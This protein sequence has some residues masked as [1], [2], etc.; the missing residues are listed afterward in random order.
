[1]ELKKLSASS[2]R[3]A[4]MCLARF[5]ADTQAGYGAHIKNNYARLG[6]SV[7]GALQDYVQVNYIDK[8]FFANEDFLIALYNKHFQ[9]E[10]QT[11]DL[12]G[13]WYEAGK[14]MLQR[15]YDR[16]D[17]SYFEV[18]SVEKKLHFDVKTSIGV[19]PVTYIIDRLDYLG[20][21]VY[22]VIDYKSSN[23]LLNPKLLFDKIQAK[24]YAL[25]M[26]I[27]LKDAQPPVQEIWVEFDMLRFTPVQTL[28]NRQQ[29]GESYR[30]LQRAA[31]KIIEAKVDEDHPIQELETLNPECGF[32]IR[33]ATCSALLNNIKVG[34]T[35]TFDTLEDMVNARALFEFQMKA[36]KAAMDE[37]NP[38][39]LAQM[40]QAELIE[41]DTTL[42]DVKVDMYKSRVFDVDQIIRIIGQEKFY[43]LGGKNVITAADFDRMIKRVT[44]AEA[45]L[46]KTEAVGF[47]YGDPR[48]KVK[49]KG[50]FPT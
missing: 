19:I 6:S 7:H 26:M 23:E 10:F 24:I 34:G 13:E 43:E 47:E 28:F 44:S 30:M 12:S 46:L 15:W 39:I 31:E 11:A 21:G 4:D 25:A 40:E 45:Q 16:T 48:V 35:Y 38:L 33:K 41:M 18:V 8:K 29:I 22:R 36:A 49:M 37:L 32:C 14:E 5:Y 2:L 50:N 1:M 20:N 27:E 9:E 42:V 3:A 17:F